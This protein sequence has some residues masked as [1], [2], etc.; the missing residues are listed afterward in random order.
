MFRAAMVKKVV[1]AALRL[2]AVCNFLEVDG[3]SCEKTM[4]RISEEKNNKK[5]YGIKYATNT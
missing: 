1:L 3:N 5:F 2:N 4:W